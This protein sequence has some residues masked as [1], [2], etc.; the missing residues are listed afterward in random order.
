MISLS[1]SQL[2]TLMTA[3]A[4]VQPDRRDIYLQ[5]VGAMLRLRYRFSDS[6]VD[7]IT[8]LARAGLVQRRKPAEMSR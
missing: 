1:D 4:S 6:D 8:R 3:T 5:R 2:K 7:E